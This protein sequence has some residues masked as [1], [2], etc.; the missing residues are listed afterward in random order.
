MRNN[1][2]LL[3]VL[4]L[5]TALT[6]CE[7]NSSDILPADGREVQ[8]PKNNTPDTYNGRAVDGYL[9]DAFVWLDINDDN[10][11]DEATE[12]SA[13]T[14]AGGY[15]TLDLSAINDARRAANQKVLEPRDYP[16]VLLALPGKTVDEA[17]E[18]GNGIVDRAYFMFAPPGSDLISPL[19]TLVRI[20]AGVNFVYSK[21]P[22]GLSTV[23]DGVDAAHNRTRDKLNRPINF[24]QDYINADVERLATYAG[25]VVR[26]IQNHTTDAMNA[27]F[28]QGSLNVY[29][30]DSLSAIGKAVFLLTAGLW[31]RLDEL[32]GENGKYSHSLLDLVEFETIS[33]DLNDPYVLFSESTQKN[34][35]L[36]ASESLKVGAGKLSSEV[37]YKYFSDGLVK[38]ITV[39]GYREQRPFYIQGVPPNPALAVETE[40]MWFNNGV[41][42]QHGKYTW[43][44][45]LLTRFEMDSINALDHD[46]TL[47][48]PVA[49]D[50]TNNSNPYTLDGV[51]E[52]STEFMR[53]T[54][55]KIS[56]IHISNNSGNYVLSYSYNETGKIK[57]IE[58]MKIDGGIETLTRIW[59]FSYNLPKVVKTNTNGVLG[60]TT[61]TVA[62]KIEEQ[63]LSSGVPEITRLYEYVNKTI[64]VRGVDTI[65][66]DYIFID[67]R[68][69][70]VNDRYLRWVYDYTTAYDIARA[71][72]FSLK[73]LDE[74]DPEDIKYI[75]TLIDDKKLLEL[76]GSLQTEVLTTATDQG[77]GFSG[78]LF[79]QSYIRNSY[80]YKRLSDVVF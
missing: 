63:S 66:T 17:A 57:K 33:L 44:D 19:T 31:D 25:G 69:R 9:R 1:L 11:W 46:A 22:S 51:P 3:G 61:I 41:I 24:L 28:L 32:A 27:Q 65:V 78:S 26:L 74:S 23:A 14:V 75:R 38:E 68:T 79:V 73:G 43:Q 76:E 39:D 67:D 70:F 52:F 2:F 42:E 48:K 5:V 64:D 29:D 7:G 18:S 80:T 77:V 6:G 50:I 49:L 62:T 13:Y 45:G 15:F 36:K 58:E 56:Q 71:A 72:G 10:T 35:E 59:T 60:E 47:S 53:D 37:I 40:Q 30:S 54:T 12:P 55:G 20:Q 16:L 8:A 21:S 34:S 4:A